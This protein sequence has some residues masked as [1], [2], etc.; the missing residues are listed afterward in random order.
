MRYFSIFLSAD[1]IVIPA[2]HD[3]N[4]KIKNIDHTSTA[5]RTEKT[6]NDDSWYFHIFSLLWWWLFCLL[7]MWCPAIHDV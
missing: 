6:K 5:V 3:H 4:H 1:T 2:D 7:Q